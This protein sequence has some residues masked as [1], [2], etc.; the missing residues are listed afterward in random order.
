MTSFGG[1]RDDIRAMGKL[2]WFLHA[3]DRALRKL[4]CNHARLWSFRFY[5]QPVSGQRMLPPATGTKIVVRTLEPAEI[6]AEQFERPPGVIE[7]RFEDG[8]VCIAALDRGSL[9]GFMWLHFGQLRERLLDCDFEA[10]PSGRSCWDYDFE[11]KPKYRLGRTF[12]RLWDEAH[13][14]LRDRGIEASVS[15]IAFS[16]QGSQRAHERMGARR[17]GWLIVFELRG[18]KLALSSI[19]PYLHAAGRGHRLYFPVDATPV[20]ARNPF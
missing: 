14:L 12:A 3:F 7:R 9:A 4:T 11:I 5:A 19:A 15:W 6:D 10:V 18:I 8:S 17:V 16:N 2:G 1:I 13:Q 20:L